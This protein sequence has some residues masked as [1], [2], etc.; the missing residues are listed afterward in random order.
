MSTQRFTPE[1]KEEVVKQV[2]DRGY[3]VLDIAARLGVSAHSLYKWVKAVSPD[4]SEQQSKDLLE[5]AYVHNCGG[6]RRSWIS[7][8]AARYRHE[9]AVT[10]MCRA[11]RVARAGFYTW[12]Y[13]PVSDHA[14]EDA[15]LL[16]LIR[17]SYRA[18]HGVYGARRIFGDP[19]LVDKGLT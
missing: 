3:G 9:H 16:D 18:S 10:S 13:G 17:A 1:F 4:K 14:K 19:G 2:I 7:Q 8:K 6:W 5:A 15:R 12:L 11:L